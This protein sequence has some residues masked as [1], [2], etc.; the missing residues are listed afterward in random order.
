MRDSIDVGSAPPMEDCA[1][2]G[3]PGY[4]ERARKECRAY[5]GLLR[6]ALG[7]EPD[8]ARLFV[9]SCRHDFGT[10]LTVACSFESLNGSAV[11]Y[12]FRCEGGGPECWDDAA[13]QE[14]DLSEERSAS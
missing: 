1:Q 8:G 7:E 11:D 14:L 12:A 6:R 13:R 4:W 10:Y 9:R 2:V 5:I 3:Q